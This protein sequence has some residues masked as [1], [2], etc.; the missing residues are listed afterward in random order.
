MDFPDDRA[1]E[2][3]FRVLGP[4][5]DAIRRMLGPEAKAFV[6]A[7]RRWLLRSD[8][9]WLLMCRAGKRPSPA[10]Y[11]AYVEETLEGMLAFTSGGA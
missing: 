3:A 7:R 5:H 10:A 8:G 2:K 4:D 1:F 11:R 9:R 6:R